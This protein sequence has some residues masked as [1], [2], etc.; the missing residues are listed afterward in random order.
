MDIFYIIYIN[1]T[2][3][4]VKYQIEEIFEYNYCKMSMISNKKCISFR[5]V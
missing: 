3:Y 1:I 2:K 4:L 5:S